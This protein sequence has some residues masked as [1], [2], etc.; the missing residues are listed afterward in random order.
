MPQSP[1]P[2]GLAEQLAYKVASGV[3]GIDLMGHTKLAGR[4]V[5]YTYGSAWGLVYG[6]FQ[7]TFSL[8]PA[9]MGALYGLLVW[10]V[11]PAMLGP[12]M[13]LVNRPSEEPRERNASVVAGHLAY[14]LGTAYMFDAFQRKAR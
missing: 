13:Q 8:P 10:S 1:G 11:G 9:L 7:A 14:G 4:T 3:F 2:E 12:S 5:H 6:L